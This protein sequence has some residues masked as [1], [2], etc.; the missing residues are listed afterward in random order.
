M[1]LNRV[2]EFLKGIK[3]EN[4][5]K[6]AKQSWPWTIDLLERL[7]AIGLYLSTDMNYHA[8]AR[9]LGM[10]TQRVTAIL[11]GIKKSK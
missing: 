11:K 10:G 2:N 6:A 8:V 4:A 7:G 5:R 1:N 9:K 3:E